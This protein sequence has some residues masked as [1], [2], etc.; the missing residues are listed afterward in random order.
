MT[1]RHAGDKFLH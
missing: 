1:F